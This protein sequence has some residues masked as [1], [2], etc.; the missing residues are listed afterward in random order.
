MR[1]LVSL[2][3][4]RPNCHLLTRTHQRAQG[5]YKARADKAY[6]RLA[7]C[8]QSRVMGIA[9]RGTVRSE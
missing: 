9:Y 6:Q 8:D 2:V 3:Q 4:T 5:L 7:W 1:V